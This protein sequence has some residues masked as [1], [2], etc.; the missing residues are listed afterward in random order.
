MLEILYCFISLETRFKILI[1]KVTTENNQSQEKV[2]CFLD[3][4]F[5]F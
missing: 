5:N 2:F 4:D 3:L 1:E